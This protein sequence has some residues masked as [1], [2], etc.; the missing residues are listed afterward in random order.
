MCRGRGEAGAGD[1][2]AAPA[3]SA[4]PEGF[5]FCDR[6]G[7]EPNPVN[8]IRTQLCLCRLARQNTPA[9]ASASSP[10]PGPDVDATPNS[11]ACLAAASSSIGVSQSRTGRGERPRGVRSGRQ[12]YRPPDRDTSASG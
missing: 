2:D 7:R 4:R 8:Q 9:S 12:A 11:N 6:E 3:E 5:I 10:G 1:D